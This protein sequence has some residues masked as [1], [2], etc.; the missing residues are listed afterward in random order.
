MNEQNQDRQNPTGQGSDKQPFGEKQGQQPTG[1]QGREQP[2]GEQG[3]EQPSFGQPETGEAQAETLTETQ[4]VTGEE[5]NAETTGE[6]DSGFVASKQSEE[7]SAYLQERGE[8]KDKS[9]IKGS[10]NFGTNGE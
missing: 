4:P 5:A 3:R 9:D 1:E 2:T 10:S 6:A 8:K 7:E